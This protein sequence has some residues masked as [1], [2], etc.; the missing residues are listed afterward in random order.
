ML[1]TRRRLTLGLGALGSG[2]ALLVAG[3]GGSSFEQKSFGAYQATVPAAY[4]LEPVAANGNISGKVGGPFFYEVSGFGSPD[5][6][7]PYLTAASGFAIIKANSGA[8]LP[9]GVDPGQTGAVPLGFGTGG[10]YVDAQFGPGAAP[11]AVQPGTSVVFRASISNGIDAGSRSVIPISPTG[12]SLTSSDPEWTLGTLPL[13]FSF[14]NTGPFASAT[15]VTGTPVQSGNGTPTPFAL[16]FKTTGIHT[17]TL[18]VTDAEGQQ[19][20]TMYVVPVVTPANVALFL[21]NFIV[22]APTTQNPN[23]TSANPITPGDTVTIDGGAGLGAYPT[24]FAPTTADAQGT[25]ILFAAPGAHTVTETDSTG[26]TV[27]TSSF[28]ITAAGAGTTIID[29]PP[30]GTT[31]PAANAGAV[32]AHSIRKH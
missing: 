24:G 32:Q 30:T 9:S 11:S 4:G 6:T 25:V 28:T 8:S 15:Y 29:V 1:K 17:V 2:A 23:A 3:C 14:N 10:S 7:M 31:T 16:P 13:T 21:Q 5:G 22:A 26:K 19:T 18:T 27:Q 20:T 12:Q